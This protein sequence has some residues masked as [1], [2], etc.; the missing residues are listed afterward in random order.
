MKLV[1]ERVSLLC[2]CSGNNN[3]IMKN[4]LAYKELR[5]WESK[6]WKFGCQ[7][8]SVITWVTINIILSLKLRIFTNP[9]IFAYIFGAQKN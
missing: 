5:V 2:L 7:D 3:K 9:S 8:N 6:A 1:G 4:Y